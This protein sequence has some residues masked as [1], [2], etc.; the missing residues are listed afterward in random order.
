MNDVKG[1]V[2][3]VTGGT[4]G[5]GEES[6][7]QL[8]AGGAKV[9]FSARRQEL[10]D[11]LE[12]ELTEKGCDV[13]FVQGDAGI[14]EDNERLMKKTI[15][16][17]GRIDSLVCNAGLAWKKPFHE[18]TNEEWDTLLAVN[19]S[20]A[21]YLIKL[22]LP[23][24]MEQKSG[25]VV[26]ISTGMIN[27]PLPE[28]G[29]YISTKAMIESLAR[30]LSLDYCRYGIRFNMLCPGPIWTERY[31][32]IPKAAIKEIL[33]TTPTGSMC[34]VSEVVKSLLF[35]VSDD[36]KI[37]YCARITPDQADA[38]GVRFD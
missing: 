36:S 6:V 10:G 30:C 14:F 9:V 5:V 19:I 35:L 15:E 31:D 29:H 38:C 25:S 8:A 13:L 18:L 24:M 1:K 33:Q 16:K 37:V 3:I 7:R 26:F 22:A 4:A 27:C 32:H 34:D 11:K 2:V 23:Y 20:S 17:Y 28:M 12:A 21:F